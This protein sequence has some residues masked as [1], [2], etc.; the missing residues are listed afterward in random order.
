MTP[1]RAGYPAAYVRRRRG[2]TNNAA[3]GK[4]LETMGRKAR[5]CRAESPRYARSVACRQTAGNGGTQSQRLRGAAPLTLR[6]FGCVRQTTGNGGAQNQRL[7]GRFI[8]P[9]L[10]RLH[11]KPGETRRRKTRGYGA[12]AALRSFG[13][14]ILLCVREYQAKKGSVIN[15]GI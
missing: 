4:P 3:F 14:R 13:Y 1:R 12:F 9:M 8:G 6:S 7:R 11:G 5:G 15:E 2:E 10:D